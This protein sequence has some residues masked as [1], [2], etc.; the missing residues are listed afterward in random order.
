[1]FVVPLNRD[2]SVR[3]TPWIVFCLVF[4]NGIILLGEY[5]GGPPQTWFASHG[6]IPARASVTSAFSSIFLHAG[7]LHYLG[8][9]FFLW[10]FGNRVEN[11]FGRWLFAFTYFLGGFGGTLFFYAL[12]LH[13]TTP[14]VG[15]SGAISGI[16][17]A[18][19]ILFPWSRF[20]LDIYLGWARLK[21][22]KTRAYVA[23]LAWFVEQAVLG[24]IISAAHVTGGVAYWA[25]VGGFAVGAMIAI[26]FTL[27]YNQKERQARDGYESDTRFEPD[28]EEFTDLKL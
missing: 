8:N 13:S 22:I 19:L 16:V 7:F 17:G 24:F 26:L 10:M 4:I 3:R 14:C 15:A 5:V 2:N 6:F 18:F 12:N 1:V 27:V 11:M 20:D 25:H 23:V 21:T 28:P 9:M